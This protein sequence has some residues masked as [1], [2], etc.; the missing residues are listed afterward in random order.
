MTLFTIHF[1]RLYVLG[2]FPGLLD[3]YFDIVAHFTFQWILQITLAGKSLIVSPI[4]IDIQPLDRHSN[5]I[6]ENCEQG[7]FLLFFYHLLAVF[8]FICE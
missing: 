5:T 7:H 2:T 4:A 8:L 1:E 6:L 3:W